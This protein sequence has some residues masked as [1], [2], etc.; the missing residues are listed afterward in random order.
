MDD[1]YVLLLLRAILG[2]SVGLI[3]PLSTG[4]LAYYF[5]PEE[6]ARLMGLS[7]AMNQ[8]GGVVATLLAGLLA[9]IEWNYAI[10]G[11]F[12]KIL[13]VFIFEYVKILIVF[14]P[15]NVKIL[16]KIE[17]ISLSNAQL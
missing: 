7:A 2:I 9:T 1:I 17:T 15:Q 5:P 3:M 13:I 12:V 6:Q 14:T 16:I 8:M 10:N 11:A 4:L